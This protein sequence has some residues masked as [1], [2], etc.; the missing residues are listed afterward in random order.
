[1][2]CTPRQ[3]R[4]HMLRNRGWCD[5]MIDSQFSRVIT[6]MNKVDKTTCRVSLALV[7]W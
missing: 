6:G 7:G 4:S 1:M 2:A 5:S 3:Y